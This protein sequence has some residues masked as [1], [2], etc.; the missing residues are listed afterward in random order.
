MVSFRSN[1]AV[2]MLFF[3][4]LLGSSAF[5]T[6]YYVDDDAP[7]SNAGT[8][9][10]DAYV[11]LQS[12]LTVAG[13]GD[14]V[15]VA[16][17]TYKP[18]ASSD[19]SIS[20][21][22]R[23]GIT[24]LGGYA[25]VHGAPDPDARDIE[26]YETILSGELIGGNSYH[27]V[28]VSAGAT[29]LLDGFLITN[30]E[31]FGEGTFGQGGGIYVQRLSRLTIENCIIKNNYAYNGGGISFAYFQTE[32]T[33]V[34]CSFSNNYAME[35]GGGINNVGNELNLT[36]CSFYRNTADGQGGGMYVEQTYTN[37]VT[38]TDCTFTENSANGS[39]VEHMG[40]GGIYGVN[41]SLVLDGCTFTKNIDSYNSGG[42][43]CFNS[44]ENTLISRSVFNG[45]VAG[46]GGGIYIY[47]NNSKISN[48]SFSGNG[49]DN[50][51]AI[52]LSGNGN[53]IINCTISENWHNDGGSGGAI[54]IAGSTNVVNCIVWNDSPLP[55]GGTLVYGSPNIIYSNIKGGWSSIGNINIVP[56]FISSADDG[57]D[58]W[59]DDRWTHYVD[60][61]A[62]NKYGD[63]RLQPGSACIDSGYS[64]AVAPGVLDLD[65]QMRIVDDPDTHDTGTMGLG[66]AVVDMGAYEG[67]DQGIVASTSSLPIPEGQVASFTVTLAR[68]PGAEVILAVEVIQGDSDI[69]ITAGQ[70]LTM[71]S[72]NYSQ[73]HSVELMAGLDADFTNGQAV[74][75]LSGAGLRSCEVIA[76]EVD[77][78]T[79]PAVIYVD[80]DAP[81]E[82]SGMNWENAYTDLYEALAVAEA[83]A[84]VVDEVRVADGLYIPK[85]RPGYDWGH[86]ALINDVT[87]KG[88]YAG[89]GATNPDQRDVGLFETVLS[90][91]L[92]GDD[93]GGVDDPSRAGNCYNVL[94]CSYND[95]TAIDG[96]TITGANSSGMEI[97][98]GSPSVNNCTFRGNGGFNGYGGVFCGG[99]S[100]T[101][102]NCLFIDNSGF[103]GGAIENGSWNLTM[104]NCVFQG[105]KAEQGDVLYR[106]GAICNSG[107]A[108]L[109]NCTFIDNSA[110]SSGNAIYNM[111]SFANL[112]LT[113]CI[114]WDGPGSEIAGDTTSIAITYSNIWGGWSG[115][116]N[117][118]VDPEIDSDLHLMADSQCID[119]GDNGAVVGISFDLEGNPRVFDGNDDGTAVV[120]MGAYELAQKNV[121]FNSDGKINLLDFAS[122]TYCWLQNDLINNSDCIKVDVSG[123]GAIGIED[124]AIFSHNWLVDDTLTAH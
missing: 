41:S 1:L 101:F 94:F 85:K 115:V 38:L 55:S 12:A 25:G 14:E 89:Y 65:G 91:D 80:Q 97:S 77:N 99:D 29:C 122:V 123:N 22:L 112:S 105:N 36:G 17:G 23:D 21:I 88:G 82:N 69:S 63:L 113:N 61:S 8:S 3:I 70:S 48:C 116:G 73:G 43:V 6:V 106:G 93:V 49:A 104:I 27:V 111:H 121:D 11:D 60:E 50:G 103:R 58:G 39:G 90:G 54:H 72:A 107:N 56:K 46:D 95:Q 96:F 7:G 2:S 64:M 28:K 13:S 44:N 40:G 67:P 62:N 124:L 26:L 18:T 52:K 100:P 114:C 118:N 32:A 92:E 10:M 75:R 83:F 78:E 117:I 5:G 15:R 68:D 33:L 66:G 74:V 20:F 109:V 19:Q 87:L 110:F 30:G 31:A 98:Y 86:F 34:N 24:W 57:G 81:G 45:N 76:I 47:G 120:D 53:E 16:Q 51:G 4:G 37:T 84:N 71:N 9:W 42:G 119:A 102:T 35:N 59:E 79:A 108:S